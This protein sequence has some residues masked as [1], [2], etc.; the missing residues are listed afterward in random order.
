MNNDAEPLWALVVRRFGIP[1][2]PGLFPGIA[3]GVVLVGSRD[4]KRKALLPCQAPRHVIGELLL[5][6][7]APEM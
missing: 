4:A 1:T 5:V 2:F 3:G 7:P 6:R